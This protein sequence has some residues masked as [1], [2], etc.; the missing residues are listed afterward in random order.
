MSAGIENKVIFDESDASWDARNSAAFH[1]DLT[2]THAVGVLFDLHAKRFVSLRI[3]EQAHGL[4]VVENRDIFYGL[5]PEAQNRKMH[6][7]LPAPKSTLVPETLY[8]IENRNHYFKLNHAFDEAIEDIDAEYVSYLKAF[9]VFAEPKGRK[10]ALIYRYPGV[11]LHHRITPWLETLTFQQKNNQQNSVHLLIEP[12]YMHIAAYKGPQLL[13]YNTFD[14]NIPEDVLY[15]T[16]FVSEQMGFDL[17]QSEYRVAGLISPIDESFK[18]LKKYT[19][20]L[21]IEAAPGLFDYAIPLQDA[22]AELIF[23]TYCTGICEL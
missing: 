12:Q 9:L 7:F 1:L 8:G 13:I 10:R 5:F 4:E 20:N 23:N 22:P 15:F 14:V 17:L 11:T 3:V 6:F 16:L 18:L 19:G 21:A 2:E